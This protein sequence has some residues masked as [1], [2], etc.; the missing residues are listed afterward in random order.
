VNILILNH[1][2]PP[3]E[4]GAA[5]A[6]CHLAREMAAQGHAVRVVTLNLF[7]GPE[8]SREGDVTVVRLPFQRRRQGSFSPLELLSYWIRGRAAVP[9]LCREF[10]PDL[11]HAFFA[12]PDGLIAGRA[13]RKL[14]IPS[15]I[16]L[17]G[18]DVPGFRQGPLAAAAYAVLRPVLRAQW[19][20]ADVRVVANGLRAL[21]RR[22]APDVDIRVVPNGVDCGRF[23]PGGPRPPGRATL[24]LLT[25]GQ[26]VPRKG[27]GELID[28]LPAVRE[29]AGR[30][31]RLK[32]IGRG[33]LGGELEKQARAAGVGDFVSFAGHVPPADM[34]R[35]YREAD[36]FVL[37][38][39]R[40]GMANAMLEALASG[41]PVV[42][43]GVEGVS[44]LVRDGEE[45]FV[46]ST[47]DR[48]A[49]VDRISRMVTDDARRGQMGRNAR[50]KAELFSWKRIADGYLA[51]YNE[52][53][54]TR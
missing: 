21:A 52:L 30:D 5:N 27:I 25:V 15:V 53:A 48:A 7:G 40:E 45:G 8:V 47:G 42:T 4:G 1:E 36:A 37:L 38:S 16:S 26:L 18:S 35:H 43:T 29:R 31:V 19:K 28:L 13:A 10:R 6:A 11:L 33:R 17:R 20:R 2:Y 34:P 49:A 46:V 14:G 50:A 12:F 32:I 9:E 54:G 23:S 41:L 44:E 22:T 24:E 3:L 39:R 51:I